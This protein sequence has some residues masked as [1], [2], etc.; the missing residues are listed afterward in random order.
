M[1]QKIGHWL[2]IA[3]IL[4]LG[5]IA[6]SAQTGIYLFT[7]AETIITLNPGV[8]D[9]TAY[10]AQGG[11]GSALVLGFNY[12]GLGADTAQLKVI[13]NQTEEH[14][15]EDESHPKTQESK[16]PIG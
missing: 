7:G 15:Q 9:I 6:S 3:V 16:R 14:I 11:S 5:V 8:Y 13:A 12:G 1:K 2:P 4:Q 10:G